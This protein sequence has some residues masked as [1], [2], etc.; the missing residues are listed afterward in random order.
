MQGGER[1]VCG[2]AAGP[3]HGACAEQW[4]GAGHRM[5]AGQQA[6]T[7]GA[8]AAICLTASPRSQQDPRLNPP[9]GIPRINACTLRV[10]ILLWLI[11]AL[12]ALSVKG[13]PQRCG[14]FRR[15]AQLVAG[16]GF[17]NSHES[18]RSSAD[19]VI[20]VVGCGA[21]LHSYGEARQRSWP[22]LRHPRPT[23]AYASCQPTVNNYS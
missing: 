17:L 14:I 13:T 19:L 7:V 6:G 9:R 4:M 2:V 10:S 11:V 1:P 22:P 3:D 23:G 21:I 20:T 12:G 8:V 18:P 15:Q 5:S 16:K